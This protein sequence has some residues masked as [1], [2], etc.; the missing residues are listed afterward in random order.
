[1]YAL[2]LPSFLQDCDFLEVGKIKNGRSCTRCDSPAL[3]VT[4]LPVADGDE[5][6]LV[7]RSEVF[8]KKVLL[9]LRLSEFLVIIVPFAIS[10]SDVQSIN[11][12]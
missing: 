10:S 7:T 12:Q 6:D 3:K 5:L 4:H 8:Q 1:M 2:L 9:R 11:L